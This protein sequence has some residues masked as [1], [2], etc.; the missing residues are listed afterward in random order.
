M[1]SSNFMRLEILNAQSSCR[2]SLGARWSPRPTAGVTQAVK[3]NSTKPLN[4]NP[5]NTHHNTQ[6]AET[7]RGTVRRSNVWSKTKQSNGAVTPCIKGIKTFVR[8]VHKLCR[9][10][11]YSLLPLLVLPPWTVERLRT[12]SC[13]LCLLEVEG[14]SLWW[15]SKSGIGN[16]GYWLFSM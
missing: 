6:D 5:Q 3:H 14:N 12:S 2:A 10:T 16:N 8:D 15:T 4:T 7:R 13:F 1:L 9:K 11:A